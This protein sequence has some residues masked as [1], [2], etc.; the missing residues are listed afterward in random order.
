MGDYLRDRQVDNGLGNSTTDWGY[1]GDDYLRP[2]EDRYWF[3]MKT[4]PG[5]ALR[6]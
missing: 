6:L 4:R 3:R 2:N 5:A 1:T